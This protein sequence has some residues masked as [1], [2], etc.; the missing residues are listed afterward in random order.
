MEENKINNFKYGIHNFTEY[1]SGAPIYREKT[2]RGGWVS[3]GEDNL[4]PEYLLSLQNRSAKHNAILQRKALMLGG[5]G[6]D[7]QLIKDEQAAIRFFNNMYNDDNLDVILYKAAYDLEIFG[8]F[9]LEIIYSK[10]GTKISEINYLPANKVRLSDDEK[11]VFYSDDW[12]NTKKF[13]PI[14]KP[15]FNPQNPTQAQ[16]LYVRE[17]RPGVEYYG[18]PDYISVVN[19]VELEYEISLYHLNQ[20]KNGFHPSMILNFSNGVPSDDEIE[21]TVRQMQNDFQGAMKAGKVMF[22]FSDGKDRAVEVTPV[23]LNNSDERFIELNKEITQGILTGHN[24][25]NPN[26]FGISVAGSLGGK[27]EILESIELFQATYIDPKMRLIEGVFNRLASFNEIQSQF[28]INPYKID[29]T[30]IEGEE[31]EEDVEQD[32]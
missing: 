22:L 31:D 13:P 21:E 1:T 18:I 2:T 7:K 9:A 4:Y 26:A 11:F 17:Y 29:F 8:A 3:Y 5:N 27:N 28:V 12:S 10:D 30:N 15:K 24:V 32:N 23:Q 14:K 19:W 16:I 25:V 6:W 20:V